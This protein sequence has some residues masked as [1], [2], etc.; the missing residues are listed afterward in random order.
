MRLKLSFLS[1]LTCLAMALL[2]SACGNKGDLF[3]VPDD[4]TQ[5]DLRRL[6]QALEAEAVS[7]SD[8]EPAQEDTDKARKDK[9]K[10][11]PPT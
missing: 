7:A 5:Q 4:I 3:L 2:V 10:N 9:T 1:S 6:E 11:T 8:V